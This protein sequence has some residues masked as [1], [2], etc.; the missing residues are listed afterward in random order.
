MLDIKKRNQ[1]LKKILSKEFGAKNVSVTGSRGTA[2]GWVTMTVK[3]PDPCPFKQDETPCS[4]YRECKDGICK[5]NNRRLGG[6][7]RNSVR[8]LKTKEITD[9]VEELIK[10]I[11]FYHYCSDDGYDTEKREMHINIDFMREV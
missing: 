2:Y 3:T 5:G 1:E 4:S 10:D 6:G 9:R 8:Q 11:E 7:W